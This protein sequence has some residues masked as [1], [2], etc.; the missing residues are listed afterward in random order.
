MTDLSH[1][2]ADVSIK[3]PLAGYD[4][5]LLLMGKIA[6]E[7][8]ALPFTSK[9]MGININSM[10]KYIQAL[11]KEPN[12]VYLAAYQGAKPVGFGYLEGGKRA[13]TYHAATLG[14][15]VLEAFSD[16]GI[17]SRLLA[18]IISVAYA[19]EN[20]AKIDLQVRKDNLKAI[21]L[22]KKFGFEVEG[23]SK[24]A[25]FINGEFF[26]YINMGKIID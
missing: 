19:S 12:A 8:N 20:I 9:D 21:R 4:E 6:D 10:K 15:G 11:N 7:T 3:K 16:R 23:M 17:G 2:E 24:R 25:L 14:I 26:D 1:K 22:Y 18:E 5:I 13:R